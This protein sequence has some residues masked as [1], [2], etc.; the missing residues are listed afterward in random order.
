MN[1]WSAGQHYADVKVRSPVWCAQRF[2]QSITFLEDGRV[3][4]VGGEHEDSYDPDFC[5]YNDV[6]VHE[7]EAIRIHGYPEDVFPPT[8]FHT[9]TLLGREIVL[10]GSLGYV[11]TRKLGVTPV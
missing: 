1:A 8:D 4:Q 9:A 5:I 7:G 2:G 3:V 10:I 6:F 11:G